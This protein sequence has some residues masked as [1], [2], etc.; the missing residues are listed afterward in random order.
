MSEMKEIVDALAILKSAGGGTEFASPIKLL[1][2]RLEKV[3]R[4]DD[5]GRE[6]D[7][8]MGEHDPR[9]RGL[10]VCV[11]GHRKST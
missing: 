7:R 10:F 4:Q 5:E 11:R 6:P 2:E 9:H 8:R 3:I 1:V